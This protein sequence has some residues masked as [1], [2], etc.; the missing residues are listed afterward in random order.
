MKIEDIHVGKH[1]FVSI[2]DSA[3][4]VTVHAKDANRVITY[5]YNPCSERHNYFTYIPEWFVSEYVEPIKPIKPI[6]LPWY[7]RIFR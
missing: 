7:K 6:K 5:I 3:F 2:S 1:Y 4:L